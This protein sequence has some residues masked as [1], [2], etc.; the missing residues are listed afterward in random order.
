MYECRDSEKGGRDLHVVFPLLGA[1]SSVRQDEEGPW[2]PI[3]S[4]PFCQ[5]PSSAPPVLYKPIS[6]TSTDEE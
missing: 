5:S 4:H 2:R 3:S 6:T 1:G